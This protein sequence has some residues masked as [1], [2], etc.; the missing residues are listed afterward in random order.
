MAVLDRLKDLVASLSNLWKMFN[1]RE[2]LPRG[3]GKTRASMC[4]FFATRAIMGKHGN[5]LGNLPDE[6]SLMSTQ[7]NIDKETGCNLEFLT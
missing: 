5:G 6:L 7:L 4:F 2:K 1:R 3:N